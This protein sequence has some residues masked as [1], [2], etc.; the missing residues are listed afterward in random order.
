MLSK[1]FIWTTGTILHT[2][3]PASTKST[4]TIGLVRQL[5][6]NTTNST[7]NR[8]HQ[9]TTFCD[10]I[11]LISRRFC[12]L[13]VRNQCENIVRNQFGKSWPSVRKRF[14]TSSHCSKPGQNFRPVQKWALLT[15][16]SEEILIFHT[17]R[18]KGMSEGM[19]L[20]SEAKIS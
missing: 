10:G 8:N 14:G 20:G 6:F 12:C 19:H 4:K 1:V 17:T 15:T 11:L 2:F 18:R 9:Y 3:A 7:Q 5:E 13:I 16:T